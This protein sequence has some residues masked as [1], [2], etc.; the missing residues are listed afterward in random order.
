[1]RKLEGVHMGA[2]QPL[3]SQDKMVI[4]LAGNPNSGKT[5]VFNSLTGARQH[6]GNWPGVTVEKK[7]GE[8]VS[9]GRAIRV[10]DLPGTYSLGAYSEDEAIARDYVLFEKP[11][12]VVNI[13]DATNLERNL[14]LTLQLLEMGANVVIALNMYDEVRAKQ[15]E[16]DAAKLSK[17]LGAPVVATTA[18][19]NEGM[20]ELVARAIQ[21]AGAG[22]QKTL[23]IN[24]GSEMESELDALEREIQS[25]SKVEGEFPTRWLAIKVLEGDENLLNKLGQY[26]LHLNELQAHRSE[27]LKR[28][29]GMWGEDIESLIA[30]RRYGFIGG[31]ARDVVLR[32]QTVE[33]RVS[34]SDRIDRIVT[35]RYLGIPIFLLAVYAIFQFTFTVG[36]PFLGWIEAFFGWLGEA[37]GTWL[38]GVGAAG[39]LSSLVVDGII[40]GVGSVLVFLPN[41]FLLFFAISILE[42]S[43]Y[44]ARAAY[45]M[46]RFMHTL[47]LHGKAFIPLLIGFGCNVPAIMSTRT[48]ENRKDRMITILINPLMSCAARLPVYILFVGAFFTANQGLV[49]FS[50]YLLGI[51]LAVLMGLLFKRFLF[52]GETSHFVMELP[53]YRVP[54]LKSTLIH[55]WERGSAFIRKAG[56]I[57]F[58]VVVLIWVLSNL[59]AGVE[60]ASQGSL[61]GQIGSFVAPIFGPAGFGHWE[62]AAAL[63]FGLLAKEVVVGTLG[64]IY[65]AEEAGLTAAIAQAWTPLS[66]YAF[67][68]MTL[69]YIPCVATIGVI[70]RETN[71][72]GWTA[73]SIGYSLLLGWLMAVLVYQGGRLFGLG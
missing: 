9:G 14:Y 1:M 59:P 66:A 7:E 30:D 38:E 48:L 35:N 72:W 28:L 17:L 55:M 44:M 40:G 73:F 36:D 34:A 47:G 67:M 52:K 11:D 3:K 31:L 19:R 69:I 62:A 57:I 43:G 33:E 15:T 70:K 39:L 21:A 56:T 10:V 18:T 49:I 61:V 42:D 60:Y 71:S 12:V 53:P 63:I 22:E 25:G 64:V 51:V 20:K 26:D 41:I 58:T 37:A 13:V 29:E 45:V 2:A 4:A 68:V 32:R 65:G 27:A 23:K 46:D 54:T 24:Y 5:T 16:I 6:V 8:I 50:L